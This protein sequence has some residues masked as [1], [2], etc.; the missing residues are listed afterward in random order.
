M[1][2][3]FIEHSRTVGNG[4][5]A[6]TP[7]SQLVDRWDGFEIGFLTLEFKFV[8]KSMM[9]FFDELNKKVM[10]VSYSTTKS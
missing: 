8:Y 7:D 1:A 10:N 5:S 2:N 9:K 3:T 4:V 6:P